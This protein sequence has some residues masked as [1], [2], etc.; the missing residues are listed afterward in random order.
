MA[1]PVQRAPLGNERKEATV[2]YPYPQ[3]RHR[4]R[5]EEGQEPYAGDKARFAQARSQQEAAAE[6]WGEEHLKAD[7]ADDVSLE[8]NLREAAID[9]HRS[10]DGR[11][12]G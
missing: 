11:S 12:G 9:V 8:D 10:L 6:A 5:K 7:D 4:D 1:R 3:D 2:S